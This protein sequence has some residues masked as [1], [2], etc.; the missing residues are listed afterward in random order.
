LFSHPNASLER[1]LVAAL[2]IGD[3]A[4]G[5]AD[6]IVV[7]HR[8]FRGDVEEE[9]RGR[10]ARLVAGA[11]VAVSVSGIAIAIAITITGITIA[12]I[13]IAITRVTVA[14]A[15]LGLGALGRGTIIPARRD[16]N[17]TSRECEN[18]SS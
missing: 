3:D 4:T 9:A 6:H 16:Q 7:D 1:D 17:E 18:R 12:G 11:G 14:I 15:G 10:G 2:T 13:A 5:R 8:V